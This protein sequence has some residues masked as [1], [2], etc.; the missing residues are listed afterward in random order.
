MSVAIILCKGADRRNE[1]DGVLP[2]RGGCHLGHLVLRLLPEC[3]G[4]LLRRCMRGLL[5]HGVRGRLPRSMRNLL[6][7]TMRGLLHRSMLSAATKVHRP[8]VTAK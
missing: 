6:H 4:G 7:R 2:L 3:N 5:H 1:T 8:P